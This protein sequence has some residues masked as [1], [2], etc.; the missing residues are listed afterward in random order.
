MLKNIFQMILI[1][2]IIFIVASLPTLFG[3]DGGKFVFN[4]KGLFVNAE[5]FLHSIQNGT[6]GTYDL[7][8][9]QHSVA[10]DIQ[11]YTKNTVILLFSSISISLLFT[12]LFGVFLFHWKI[13]FVLRWIINALSVIPDF[14]IIILSIALAVEFYQKTHIRVVTL[15][16]LGGS[17]NLWFPIIILSLIPT[18]YLFKVITRKYEE[19]CG[20]DY[21]RTSVSKG[22]GKQYIHL[23]HVYRNLKPYL[24]ADLKKAVSITIGSLFI[25]EYLFNIRGLT[26]F[27]FGDDYQFQ[28]VFISLLLLLLVAALCYFV[29]RLIFF[30]LEKVFTHD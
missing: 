12:L 16:P 8:H 30:L 29:I 11:S 20:E 14:I 27:I 17:V 15:S 25:V 9:I 13:S 1:I 22:L 21:I 4:G 2:I 7:N 19:I 24:F 23:Q 6:F 18:F 3:M 5:S 26:L 10:T 28:K